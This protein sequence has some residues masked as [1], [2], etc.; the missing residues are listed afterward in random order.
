MGRITLCLVAFI[1]AAGL[2]AQSKQ[3]SLGVDI[4]I[5]LR[6]FDNRLRLGRGP[7]V[8]FELPVGNTL[9]VTLQGAYDIMVTSDSLIGIRLK[10]YS[11]IP[12]Q[13]GLKYYPQGQQKGFYGHVQL[14]I[15]ITR[16]RFYDDVNKVFNSNDIDPTWAIGLGYQLEH[17]DFGVRYNPLL[18][19]KFKEALGVGYLGVRVAYLFTM[20]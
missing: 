4:V 7:A 11:L 6:E 15:H 18:D 3:L 13:A 20:D 8:G 9:G 2:F 17:V 1:F 12:F 5:P 19:L 16:S 10:S 14:G